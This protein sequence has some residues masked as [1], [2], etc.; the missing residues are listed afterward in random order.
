MAR[1]VGGVVSV[2]G[3]DDVVVSM[4]VSCAWEMMSGL[5]E[6]ARRTRSI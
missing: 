3:I 6:N 1:N 5:F 4:V 2:G